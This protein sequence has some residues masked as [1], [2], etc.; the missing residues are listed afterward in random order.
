MVVAVVTDNEAS[1]RNAAGIINKEFGILDI[2]CAA[3]TVQLIV[4]DLFNIEF[5]S[6]FNEHIDK[7]LHGYKIDKDVKRIFYNGNDIQLKHP[8]TTRWNS[9]Y[10]SYKTM[11]RLQ[12]HLIHVASQL[13]NVKEIQMNVH[14]WNMLADMIEILTPFAN[15]TDELQRDGAT[16][17]SVYLAFRT[18]THIVT[19][20]A[21][22][23]KYNTIE[24]NTYPWGDFVKNSV[25]KRYQYNIHQE[26]VKLVDLLYT[27]S[28]RQ[29]L[30][31]HQDSALQL[32][33][34]I[35]VSIIKHC[36]DTTMS[37]QEIR[38][39]LINQWTDFK[40]LNPPYSITI[41]EL[42]LYQK[43]DYKDALSYW[44]RRYGKEESYELSLVALA[45]IHINPSEAAVERS[46]SK[47]KFIHTALRNS[48]HKDTIESL[49]F[50][51][52]NTV[53]LGIVSNDSRDSTVS[54]WVKDEPFL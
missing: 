52:V 31:T 17:N 16:L 25:Y 30:P 32:L 43:N 1:M 54:S 26:A 36:T 6:A 29:L 48:L 11:K 37:D 22:G 44:I 12:S 20:N 2:P 47:Q 24:F 21:A 40:A 42:P 5:I 27:S 33:N 4:K 39:K 38:A 14:D 34:T 8:N 7:L 49:M 15:V 46:F 41:N 35:G 23:K 51:K 13:P 18:I 10:E 53:A 45:M 28:D 50:V 19:S 3:H 9:R